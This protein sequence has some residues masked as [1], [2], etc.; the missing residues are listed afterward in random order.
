MDLAQFLTVVTNDSW[1]GNTSGAYQHERYAVLRAVENRR[2]VVQCANGGI[3]CFVDP[4]GR[5]RSS[6]ELYTERAFIGAVRPRTDVTFYAEH[7]DWFAA[8]CLVC[9][10]L[11]VA[12]ALALGMSRK[13]RSTS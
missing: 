2:W 11:A 12:G 6:T 4:S 8:A 5:V 1:W 10:G 9:S 7:G 13:Q 3:S